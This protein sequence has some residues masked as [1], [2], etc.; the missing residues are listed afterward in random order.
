MD[1]KE[2]R[3]Q[4]LNKLVEELGRGGIADVARRIDKSPDYVSRMLYEPGKAGRKG[5][6]EDTWAALL[7]AYPQLGVTPAGVGTPS[8]PVGF[9]DDTMSQALELLYLVADTRPGEPEYQRPTWA[10]I[11]IAAKGI[12]RAGGDA[13]KAL[14]KVAYELAEEIAHAAGS[15][16]P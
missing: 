7:N 11:K 14:P 2:S 1:R 12:L 10:M 13:R 3:R 16:R 8:Q 15:D 5:I 9:D 6:G 4:A